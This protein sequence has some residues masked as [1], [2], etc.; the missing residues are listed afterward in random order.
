MKRAPYPQNFIQGYSILTTPWY[1]C[2]LIL[3]YFTLP[4]PHQLS[5]AKSQVL[6]FK[7]STFSLPVL[8]LFFLFPLPALHPRHPPLLFAQ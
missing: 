8:P 5:Y 1:I 6:G 3:L 2:N 7:I 4:R